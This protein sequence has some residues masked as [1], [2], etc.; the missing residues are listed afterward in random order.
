MSKKCSEVRLLGIGNNITISISKI[1]KTI[2]IIK[3]R[4]ENE[5]RIL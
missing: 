3:N 4:R 2:L 5:L 1:R